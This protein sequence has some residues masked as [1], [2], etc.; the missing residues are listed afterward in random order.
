M[1]TGSILFAWNASYVPTMLGDHVAN[2]VWVS[3][4]LDLILLVSLFVLGGDFWDK[5]QALFVY[6]ARV[7]LPSALDTEVPRP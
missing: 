2:R 6:D 3:M 4:G 7:A 5:L 1:F